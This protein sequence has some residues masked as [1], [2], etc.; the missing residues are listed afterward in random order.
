MLAENPDDE[1]EFAE[2]DA[3]IS[4]DIT[5]EIAEE[6]AQDEAGEIEEAPEEHS[7]QEEELTD[8][9][10]IENEFMEPD[11]VT[12]STEEQE[13]E[14]AED[15]VASTDHE[16]QPVTEDETAIELETEPEAETLE[17]DL[18]LEDDILELTEEETVPEE[19]ASEIVEPEEPVTKKKEEKQSLQGNVFAGIMN[20]KEPEE[21]KL[22]RKDFAPEPDVLPEEAET[23]VDDVSQ[24][25]DHTDDAIVDEQ[26]IDEAISI[27]TEEV[28]QEYS[29]ELDTTA[30]AEAEEEIDVTE[31]VSLD[32]TE[33]EADIEEIE[34]AAEVAEEENEDIATDELE[35]TEEVSL[36]DQLDNVETPEADTSFSELLEDELAE[37]SDEEELHVGEPLEVDEVTDESEAV[38]E[39][40]EATEEESTAELLEA[41]EV[42]SIPESELKDEIETL[43]VV[44][45]AT[46]DDE[47]VPEAKEDEI[48]TELNLIDEIS[49]N[50]EPVDPAEDAP[51]EAN[52]DISGEAE[53]AADRPSSPIVEDDDDLSIEEL[54]Q[55]I[56]SERKFDL[57]YNDKPER[58]ES[59]E[60]IDLVEDTKEE[61][62]DETA[63]EVDE[64]SEN[65]VADEVQEREVQAE[66][67]DEPLEEA[68]DPTS[69]SLTE[70]VVIVEE[71]AEEANV[72]AAVTEDVNVEDA[73]DEI[74]KQ[75]APEQEHDVELSEVDQ[76]EE[77]LIIELDDQSQLSNE[78]QLSDDVETEAEELAP[79]LTETDPA[80]EVEAEEELSETDASLVADEPQSFDEP[81]TDAEVD[82]TEPE[83]SNQE[84][85]NIEDK[86]EF[87]I[88]ALLDSESPA[89]EDDIILEEESH[90]EE[91]LED[92]ILK[93]EVIEEADHETE[94]E[95]TATDREEDTETDVAVDQP[96]TDE[97]ISP[98]TEETQEVVETDSVTPAET[99]ELDEPPVAAVAEIADKPKRKGSVIERA[100]AMMTP[101]FGRKNIEATD[102]PETISNLEADGQSEPE[103]PALAGQIDIIETAQ[104]DAP[105][106]SDE[107]EIDTTQDHEVD[108]E[109]PAEDPS[110]EQSA[111]VTEEVELDDIEISETTDDLSLTA[112]QEE[113]LTQAASDDISEAEDEADVIDLSEIAEIKATEA[114]QE[115]AD[116]NEVEAVVETDEDIL[117][118]GDE[119]TTI[120]DDILE[121]L[122]GSNLT[123]EDQNASETTI[124]NEEE[125]RSDIKEIA[126]EELVPADVDETDE[127]EDEDEDEEKD[128]LTLSELRSTL[129]QVVGYIKKEDANH[130][131]S[132]DSLYN[133]LT[134]IYEFHKNCERAP[135]AYETI[136]EEA[137]LKIQSR[138]PYTPVL[139]ICLGKD[140]DKTRLTE[141]AA[142]LGIAQ[143]MDVEV[144]EFHDFIKNFPGG[145]KGCVKEMRI[146]RKHGAS[147]N[148]LA[149]KTKS[150]EEAR[151]IL[152][153]MAPIA[154]FRLK[155]VIVGNTVDEFCLLLAKRDGHDINV[156]K[157]IDDKHTKIDPII[158]RTAFIKGNLNDRK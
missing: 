39:N 33:P 20:L 145:I 101:S 19:P 89:T 131:R 144:D 16:Y 118:T 84:A 132:R 123:E 7:L 3:S 42:P 21:K 149:Q 87:D 146:I 158:K 63:T 121:E 93:E 38:E 29:P 119:T 129:K 108:L 148:V 139:K 114:E 110:T 4:E 79:E 53:E 71:D 106:T 62:V 124:E 25:E 157:I 127:D 142:A 11:T 96:E 36:V 136:V 54:M 90:D 57:A 147:G 120:A 28:A 113:N 74:E 45:D 151:A 14:Q 8:I 94:G 43:D 68:E 70:E 104:P 95:L 156:L 111:E 77:E 61:T 102:E 66:E 137:D 138:A 41:D 27:D 72:E 5:E 47:T 44:V 22:V 15:N 26:L 122:T 34:P 35:K 37:Q 92:E 128:E 12:A 6:V 75:P 30:E 76:G 18:H 56:I 78:R 133:I 134:A 86:A 60:P 155:K 82:Q 32:L 52:L 55:S 73:T 58:K 125:T 1:L 97:V 49:S 150:V 154:R 83:V 2:D 9:E 64:T 117:I 13:V 85:E 153:E 143:Y 17:E 24:S 65:I 100:M 48:A 98:D 109:K 105:E 80:P 112:D 59:D 126:E 135:E 81:E 40:L 67:A 91:N 152:R 51:V 10:T 103:Q 46:P 23:S 130:N 99:V 88:D 50:Q 31:A 141:Y 69:S 140:Y 116:V 107:N 115:A